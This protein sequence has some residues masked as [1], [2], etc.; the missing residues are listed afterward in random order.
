MLVSGRAENVE[1]DGRPV[2]SPSLT[3]MLPTVIRTAHYARRPYWHRVS[4][5]KKNVFRRDNYTCQ[6]CGQTGR[7]LTVDHVIPK[8]RGGRTAWENVVVACKRCN[9]RK[10]NRTLSESGL[11][12]LRAPREPQVLL[13]YAHPGLVPKPL[14]ES[15]KKYL[16]TK[17][18]PF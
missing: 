14:W 6:Y 9:L 15:W 16:Y 4:F 7:N 11:K 13:F 3:I 5:S 10:G 17:S 18:E 2:R 12:L 8:S 1:Y